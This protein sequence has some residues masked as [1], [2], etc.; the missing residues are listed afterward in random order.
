MTEP[1]TAQRTLVRVTVVL[2]L[3]A[4]AVRVRFFTDVE[5][6]GILFHAMPAMLAVGLIYWEEAI[7]SL[8]K[9]IR[10]T[11]IGLLLVA[12]A[13]GEGTICVILAAP[14]VY[15][16]AAIVWAIGRQ[17]SRLR[18]RSATVLAAALAM[19]VV[20]GATSPGP[21]EIATSVVVPFTVDEAIGRLA[22]PIEIPPMGDGLLARRLPQLAV[23]SGEGL[24]VGDRRQMEFD[25]GS[26]VVMEVAER[27]DDAVRLTMVED[28][29]MARTWLRWTETR[30]EIASTPEGSRVA[31]VMRYELLLDPAWYFG[32]L[33]AAGAV[34]AADHVL[35]GIFAP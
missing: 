31:M 17:A 14:L 9:V 6:W 13:T 5:P 28:T 2:L 34:E 25:D 23:V 26:R 12:T 7:T 30:F 21:S 11:T 10:G 3:A 1:T 18:H 8:G 35:E 19:S 24:D 29:T 4:V 32:P 20:N 22:G 16:V 27:S 15:G 33:V